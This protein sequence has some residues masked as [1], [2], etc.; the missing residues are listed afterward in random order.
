MLYLA[1]GIVPFVV[2]A[3][4]EVADAVYS[5]RN[6]HKRPQHTDRGITE[7]DGRP[8]SIRT[9]ELS[10]NWNGCRRRHN[11]NYKLGTVSSWGPISLSHGAWYND[12]C[13]T[14]RVHAHMSKIKARSPS[15]FYI[16]LHQEEFPVHTCDF[17]N[18]S[19]RPFACHFESS[20][21]WGVDSTAIAYTDLGKSF[22]DTAVM[23]IVP[24]ALWRA[25]LHIAFSRCLLS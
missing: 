21:T 7:N 2:L 19:T 4:N 12:F 18:C 14:H 13:Y 8:S 25:V 3:A 6:R 10:K 22:N 5:N 1:V 24:Y 11:W 20:S 15:V 17:Q 9:F 16:S 23:C